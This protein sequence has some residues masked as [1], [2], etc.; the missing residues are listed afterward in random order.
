MDNLREGLTFSDVLLVPK[1]TP[2]KSRRQANLKTRFSKNVSLNIPLVSSNM[3]TVTGNEMAIALARA[4]GIGVVHQFCSVKDQARMIKEV[5]KSTCFIVKNPLTCTKDT[6]FFQA[7]KMMD[8]KGVASI[9]VVE[10]EK[11]IGIVTKRD[12]LYVEADCKIQD[13]MTSDL[14]TAPPSISLDDAKQILHKNKIEKLVLIEEDKLKGLITKHD[15]DKID[16]YPFSARDKEGRLLVAGA[17]GV[18]DALERGKALVEAGVDVLVLDIA[19]CHSDF[20]IKKIKE[21]KANFKIDVVAGNIA[22][23]EGAA[24]LIEAGVDGLKVGI[25]P[26]PVCSTRTKSGA[27]IPQLTAIWDVVSVAK[28]HDVPVIADG[29]CKYPGDV[30]K[31]LAAGASSVMSGSFFAGSDEAPGLIIIKEGKRYKR[32]MGSASYDNNHE[33]TEKLNGKQIEKK[34]D[35]Y[36]EGVSK[37]VDYKGPVKEVID[38][39]CKGVQSAISY[40][41]SKNIQE[42]QEKAEFIKITS[43]GFQES[44]TH[45]KKLSD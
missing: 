11:P 22:T 38:A 41:G 34:L 15:L 43:A 45:G 42:M 25:G 33:K 5:K 19:H 13:L 30:A 17:V 14:V 23:A 37:L 16:K 29:G 7:K 10:K 39:L 31:A 28:K 18:K 9:I 3:V 27:G 21:L 20:A 1:R 6:S 4:G 35:V 8:E 36:V 26:S 44:L 2:L 40:C 32:Y 24:D 12:Y